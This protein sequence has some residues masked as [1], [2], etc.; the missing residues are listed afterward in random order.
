[1]KLSGETRSPNTGSISQYLPR[2]FSRCDEWPSRTMW[3][4]AGSSA[5][6]CARSSRRTGIGSTGVVPGGA[7]SRKR[8]QIF[9]PGCEGCA[10]GL[11][12][13]WNT[14]PSRLNCGDCAHAGL[15]ACAD[16]TPAS[17]MGTAASNTRAK[18]AHPRWKD[19]GAA[20]TVVAGG[21]RLAGDSARRP[22]RVGPVP[23][24]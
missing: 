7:G 14:Q 1:M 2:S 18:R 9:Q 3:F 16:A 22:R 8:D 21:C 19:R 6:S 10:V 24:R 11:S 23:L 13:F 20:C 4:A 15:Q 17:A 12:M 5:S